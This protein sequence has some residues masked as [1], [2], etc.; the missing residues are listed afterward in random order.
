[1]QF[2]LTAECSKPSVNLS[3]TC[4][5]DFK[6]KPLVHCHSLWGVIW[7]NVWLTVATCD[8]LFSFLLTIFNIVFILEWVIKST[9]ALTIKSERLSRSS[10]ALTCLTGS[11][12]DRYASPQTEEVITTGE[13]RI[14]L[15][16]D[17]REV[18]SLGLGVQWCLFWWLF[19]LS[20]R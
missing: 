20:L 11:F 8:R 9:R 19:S 17:W 1:M 16:G 18:P 2:I 15:L 7:L 3:F 4:D 14:G 13:G 5:A 10:A 6:M 12:S